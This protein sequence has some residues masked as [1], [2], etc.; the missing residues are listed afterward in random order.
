MAGIRQVSVR[1]EHVGLWTQ[2][3]DQMLGF[4]V[5]LLGGHAGPLY[6]NSSTGFRSCFVAFGEGARVEL[7]TRPGSGSVSHLRTGHD[8]GGYAHI[9]LALPTQG[10]VR[11]VTARLQ[12]A[13]IS[14]ASAPRLTGD[15]YYESVVLDPEGNRVELVASPNRE[16]TLIG[17]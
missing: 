9:A 4:Y 15:G 17:D 2:D 5:G 13:G 14:L 8:D 6:V 7:M 11:R 10:D 1:L 3:L 12:T 16:A